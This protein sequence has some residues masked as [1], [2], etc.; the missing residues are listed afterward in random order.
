MADVIAEL[1][2]LR[3]HGMAATWAELGEQ[4]NAEVERSRWLLEHMLQAEASD[5][6]T[7]SVQHQMSSA[8]L[9]QF[10]QWLGQVHEAGA[11]AQ[12]A[13]LA[14]NRRHIV[15]PVVGRAALAAEPSV[16]G[17]HAL[18]G[19]DHH[20]LRVQPRADR[21]PRQLARHRVAVA[22]L[23]MAHSHRVCVLAFSGGMRSSLQADVL[24]LEELDLALT[25]LP[26]SGTSAVTSPSERRS[27]GITLRM[28]VRPTSLNNIQKSVLLR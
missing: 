1:K 22:G 25:D 10:G 7:R 6:A 14:L 9:P 27:P 23:R 3:M 8:R 28:N 11:V 15:L 5:R 26:Q 18:V 20:A 2:A 17:H 19:H 12:R 4:H 24:T 21:L 16:L 13:G